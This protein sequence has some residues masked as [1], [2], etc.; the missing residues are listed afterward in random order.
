VIRK[1]PAK[2]IE[3]KYWKK[4][5]RV[6]RAKQSSWIMHA[7]IGLQDWR[8]DGTSRSR[9][10][11]RSKL[12]FAIDLFLHLGWLE[13]FYGLCKAG[14]PLWYGRPC[15]CATIKYVAVALWSHPVPPS[16]LRTEERESLKSYLVDTSFFPWKQTTFYAY[17][18]IL[19][20]DSFFPFTHSRV[21]CPDIPVRH[22][23]SFPSNGNPINM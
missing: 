6:V 15:T 20:S 18:Q 16:L 2:V 7:D 12:C 21:S 13:V 19:S 17:K 23:V 22:S 3:R 9:I 10:E 11:T 4:S 5:Y 8:L 14:D 1:L